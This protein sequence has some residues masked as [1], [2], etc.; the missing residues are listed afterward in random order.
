[1]VKNDI[2]WSCFFDFWKTL[3]SIVLGVVAPIAIEINNE[4]LPTKNLNGCF[5]KEIWSAEE[6]NYYFQIA[7]IE[8][9]KQIYVSQALKL[10]RNVFKVQV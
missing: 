3:V 4:E 8:A 7:G 10:A 6:N 1:M 9:I 5:T 2:Y